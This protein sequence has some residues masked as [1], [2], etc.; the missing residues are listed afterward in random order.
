MEHGQGPG[1]FNIVELLPGSNGRRLS[2]AMSREHRAIFGGDE[3]ETK[4]G[5]TLDWWGSRVSPSVRGS[6]TAVGPAANLGGTLLRA[7]TRLDAPTSVVGRPRL[8]AQGLGSLLLTH[9][10]TECGNLLYQVQYFT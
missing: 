4:R 8:L 5:R 3:K 1:V 10:F 2:S 9:L 6:R 7:E